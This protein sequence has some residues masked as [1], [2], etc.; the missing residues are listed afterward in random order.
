MALKLLADTSCTLDFQDPSHSG[1]IVII[2]ASIT[3]SKV[4]TQ[5]DEVYLSISF[6]VTAFVGPGITSGTGA[7]VITGSTTKTGCNSIS[8]IRE[9]DSVTIVIT[10][11]VS[12]FGTTNTTVFVDD[13]GQTKA[14]A[15]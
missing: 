12:P 7:G 1:T 3:S 14:K 6:T 11:T 8:P 13:A 5:S 2:P 9:D 4:K 10:D 15:Q